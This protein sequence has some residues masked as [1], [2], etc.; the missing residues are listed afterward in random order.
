MSRID[1][2]DAAILRLV[3]E[4][5]ALIKSSNQKDLSS[6]AP[7]AMQFHRPRILQVC[8]SEDGKAGLVFYT[9]GYGWQGVEVERKACESLIDGLLR[10]F[11]A[12]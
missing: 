1:E 8:E 4:R 7:V 2:I 3:Q 9:A 11:K 12:S 10:A 5:V 6:V